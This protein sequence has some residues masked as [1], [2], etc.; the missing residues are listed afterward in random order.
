M[1]M[2]TPRFDQS[3]SPYLP[4]VSTIE[5]HQGRGSELEAVHRGDSSVEAP[6]SAGE[7]P[8]CAEE[9]VLG[10]RYDSPP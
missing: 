6:A 7:E 2:S 1:M 3:R 10:Y 9:A 5:C 8:L 4:L